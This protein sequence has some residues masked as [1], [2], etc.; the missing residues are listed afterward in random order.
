MK[1]YLGLI[2]LILMYGCL[3]GQKP[4]NNQTKPLDQTMCDSHHGNWNGTVCLCG[5]I[6]GFSCPAGYFCTDYIP[7]KETPD[8]MG[9]C[10][11]L[12][13]YVGK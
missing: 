9:I 13:E 2:A 1:I 5:G 3:G 4:N 8:A 12:G 7:N 6:A 11:K 10:S